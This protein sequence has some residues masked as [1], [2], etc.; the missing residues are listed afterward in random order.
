MRPKVETYDI[1]LSHSNYVNRLIQMLI[2][3]YDQIFLVRFL[4]NFITMKF[5]SQAWFFLIEFVEIFNCKSILYNSSLWHFV[6]NDER[7]N[8]F[9]LNKSQLSFNLQFLLPLNT[10]KK[11]IQEEKK[12]MP[13]KRKV[14][15][16]RI[17]G[18]FSHNLTLQQM[19]LS[20]SISFS[21]I[22]IWCYWNCCWLNIV[23]SKNV[24]DFKRTTS[25]CFFN[26]RSV[27]TFQRNQTDRFIQI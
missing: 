22:L 5:E 8:H 6:F 19:F 20:L 10:H 7:E 15:D 16:V 14:Q 2:I 4:L 3:Y 9:H 11:Q 18:N 1:I 12:E 24:L 23:F 21:Y 25:F 26:S 13:Q 17:V 27:K